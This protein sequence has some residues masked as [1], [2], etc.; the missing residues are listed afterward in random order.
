MERSQESKGDGKM[1]VV[2]ISVLVMVFAGCMSGNEYMLRKEQIRA[3]AN[4]QKTFPVLTIR[5]PVDIKE[6]AT[7]TATAPTQPY[8]VIPIP[9]GAATQ[10]DVIKKV[11]GAAV[12]G[13]GVSRIG[14]SGDTTIN[15]N[16]TAEGVTP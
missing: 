8:D 1:R 10:A 12:I 13:Y 3:Q 15:N 5:G 16:A 4:H 6:G 11:V 9:D 2:L 7:L 14:D